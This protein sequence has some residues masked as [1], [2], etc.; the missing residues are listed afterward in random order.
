MPRGPESNHRNSSQDVSPSVSPMSPKELIAYGTGKSQ[1]GKIAQTPSYHLEKKVQVDTSEPLHLMI[2]SNVFYGSK[3]CD[4]ETF[5]KHMQ[6]AQSL[7]NTRVIFLGNLISN[8]PGRNINTDVKTPEEQVDYMK[9]WIDTLDAEGKVLT[10]VRADY[11]NAPLRRPDRVD[12]V[13]N[14]LFEGVSFPVMQNG[15]ILEV[16]IANAESGKKS[17]TEQIYRLGLF[18]KTG[19]SKAD[20]NKNSGVKRAFFEKMAGNADI[21]IISNPYIADVT[22]T[23]VGNP[24]TRQELTVITAGG[25]LGNVKGE[26]PE[27]TDKKIRDQYGVD[28]EPSGQVIT[29]FSRTKETEV[30]LKP[31]HF[32]YDYMVNAVDKKLTLIQQVGK[33]ADFSRSLTR[34]GIKLSSEEKQVIFQNQNYINKLLEEQHHPQRRRD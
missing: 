15:G 5:E 1:E 4:V 25:Y 17:K 29:L 10:A 2:I 26:R 33:E 13:N 28:G 27:L 12:D 30:Y 32:V 9:G 24:P 18:S 22:Q 16:G 11:P 8:P 20:L 19:T 21:A 3:F 34:K 7:E 6:I 31:E 23:I 14:V